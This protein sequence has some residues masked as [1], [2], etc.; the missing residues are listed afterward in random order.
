MIFLETVLKVS[1]KDQYINP[2]YDY[3][4]LYIYIYVPIIVDSD[5]NINIHTF[6][7]LDV[8]LLS[9]LHNRITSFK[10][11]GNTPFTNLLFKNNRKFP[12]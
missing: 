2:N 9:F 8:I 6:I 10:G 4:T 3:R 11:Y 5:E 1:K 7:F 12:K